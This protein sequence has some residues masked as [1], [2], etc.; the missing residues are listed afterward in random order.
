VKDFLSQNPSIPTP[1]KGNQILAN[2]LA[3]KL[4][5]KVGFASTTGRGRPPAL[6][7]VV[8]TTTDTQ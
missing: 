1:V 6:Y 4:V 8:N 5:R 7:E 3:N 2:L